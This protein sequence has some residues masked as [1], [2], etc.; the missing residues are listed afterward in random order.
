MDSVLPEAMRAVEAAANHTRTRRILRF[1]VPSE[2][3]R[4]LAGNLGIEQQ[5]FAMKPRI[6]R[7]WGASKPDIWTA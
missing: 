6:S 4:A 2:V 1:G 3:I 7:P 5:G